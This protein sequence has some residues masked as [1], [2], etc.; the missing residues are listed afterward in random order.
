MTPV[1]GTTSCRVTPWGDQ[2]CSRPAV[3]RGHQNQKPTRNAVGV[4]GGVVPR[5]PG[6]F[7]VRLGGGG[8][9]LVREQTTALSWPAAGQGVGNGTAPGLA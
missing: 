7:L 6:G 5:N 3:R 9:A 8:E 4:G 2:K 1:A